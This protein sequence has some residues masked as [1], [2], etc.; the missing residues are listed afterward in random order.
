MISFHILTVD[1]NMTMKKFKE[2]QI[3]KK[4]IFCT[5]NR[6]GNKF[7]IAVPVIIFSFMS[8]K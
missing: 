7:I 5:L 4:K 6:R 3:T 2:L 1:K 8:S